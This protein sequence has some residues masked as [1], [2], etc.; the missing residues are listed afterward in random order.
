[1]ERR[2]HEQR[3][4]V[5]MPRVRIGFPSSDSQQRSLPVGLHASWRPRRR[6]RSE[7]GNH[8]LVTSAATESIADMKRLPC[9]LTLDRANFGP[10]N[11]LT[12]WHLEALG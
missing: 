8:H 2:S 3:Q 1:M 5:A 10:I 9:F 12:Y 11:S 6:S 7:S 4:Q